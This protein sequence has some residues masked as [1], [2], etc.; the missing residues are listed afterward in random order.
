MTSP[1]LPSPV[2]SPSL[3]TFTFEIREILSRSV[4]V[5]ANCLEE[6]FNEVYCRYRSMDI[7]LT[8]EDFL[9]SDILFLE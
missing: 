7:V 8:A 6:A 5:Q 3:S 2:S 9:D 4:T 1:S